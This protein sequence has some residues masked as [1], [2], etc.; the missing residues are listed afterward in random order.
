MVNMTD[1]LESCDD[2]ASVVITFRTD[3]DQLKKLEALS[4]HL[5]CSKSLIIRAGIRSFINKILAEGK[6]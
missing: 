5:K 3:E 2:K 1:M 4:K 6:I